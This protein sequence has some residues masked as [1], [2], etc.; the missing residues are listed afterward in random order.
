MKLFKPKASTRFSGY[1]EEKLS[2]NIR[3]ELESESALQG[4]V[5]SNFANPRTFKT[6]RQLYKGN[7]LNDWSHN[8]NR[9]VTGINTP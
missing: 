9:M 1:N 2:M 8:V 5:G 7:L 4:Y 3:N 6:L